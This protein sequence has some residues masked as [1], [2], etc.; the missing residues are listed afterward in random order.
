MGFLCSIRAHV[1]DQRHV[2]DEEQCLH[3]VDSM[4]QCGH[5]GTR[6]RGRHVVRKIIDQR[7]GGGLGDGQGIRGAPCCLEKERRW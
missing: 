1:V 2:K 5:R 6:Q 3:F 4:L 7:G